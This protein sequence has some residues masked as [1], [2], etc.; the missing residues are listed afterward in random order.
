MAKDSDETFTKELNQ[1]DSIDEN[2]E[3][4]LTDMAT[5]YKKIT[6]KLLKDGICFISKKKLKEP[7]DVVQV[8]GHKIDKGMIAFIAVNKDENK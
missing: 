5:F 8:P 1:M 7:F 3:L 2:V 4:T 6:T